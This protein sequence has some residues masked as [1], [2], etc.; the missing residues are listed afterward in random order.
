MALPSQNNCGSFVNY[1]ELKCL[2]INLDLSVF[3]L[4]KEEHYYYKIFYNVRT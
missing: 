2:A 1:S 3:L 4:L